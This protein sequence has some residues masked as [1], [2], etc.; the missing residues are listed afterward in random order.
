MTEA[1]VSYQFDENPVRVVM[2]ADD[3]WFVA[4]DVARVLGYNRAPDMIRNLDDDEKGVHIVHT[5]G[6]EQQLSIVSES[7]LYAAVLKSRRPEAK[8][9]RKWVTS[10][11]LPALRRD[12]KYQI[13]GHEGY[14]ELASDY[15]PTRLSAAVAVIRE[16]RRLYGPAGARRIWT[17]LG[18]PA[19]VAE[20]KPDG[21]EPLAAPL[22]EWMAGRDSATIDEAAAGIGIAPSDL[23]RATRMRLGALMSMFGWQRRQDRRGQWNGKV[24][25]RPTDDDDGEA[26][27]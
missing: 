6:G 12:G 3:P 11:V 14:E 15:D 18:L 20:S 27:Q 24:W 7:G 22:R 25:T 9:F 13:P 26:D 17:K 10:E 1:L 8:K 16:A 19:A 2:I 23:D 5:L 4:S 21:D